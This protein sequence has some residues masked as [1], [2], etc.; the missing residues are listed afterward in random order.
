MR[1]TLILTLAVLVCALAV[2]GYALFALNDTVDQA[3]QLHSRAMLAADD[4]DGDRAAALLV[5][6][7]QLWKDRAGQMETLAN[8]D[9][10]HDVAAA[11]AEA[12]ICLECHDRDDFLRTMSTVL[13]GLEHLKDDEAVRWENLY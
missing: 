3:M 1:R 9:A 7:A 2:C 8:H 12:Q 5:Q 4:G 13:L 11:I 10:L 6:L